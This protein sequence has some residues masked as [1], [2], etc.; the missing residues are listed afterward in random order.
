MDKTIW[1]HVGDIKISETI[2]NYQS[3]IGEQ[4]ATAKKNICREF[5]ALGYN[6]QDVIFD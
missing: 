3:D 5:E 4:I 2:K 1:G 6:S